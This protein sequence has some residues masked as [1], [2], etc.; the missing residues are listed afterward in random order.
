MSVIHH[1]LPVVS[2]KVVLQLFYQLA[3]GCCYW[4]FTETM[5][6]YRPSLR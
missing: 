6:M 3:M 4:Q 2:F 1:P 5:P